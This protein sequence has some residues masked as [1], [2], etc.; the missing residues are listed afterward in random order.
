M[1][2]QE[3]ILT[4][5]GQHPFLT[6]IVICCIYYA[7]KAPFICVKRYIRSR[8]IQAHGWPTAPLNSDGSLMDADGDIIK[9]EDR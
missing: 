3:F 8:D 5:A 6:F 9:R 1:S 2:A 7:W 4:F